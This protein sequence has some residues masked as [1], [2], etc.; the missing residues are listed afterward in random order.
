MRREEA[1]RVT[2]RLKL[3]H[4]ALSL[5]GDL[6]GHLRSVVRVLRGVVHHRWDHRAV[7]V[8]RELVGDETAR[9]VALSFQE[10]A[11]KAC[12]RPPVSARLHENVDDVPVLVDPTPQVP[13][14]P[15]NR[16]KQL[17]QIPPVTKA[18]LTAP[19]PT[20]IVESKGLTP[21]PNRFV[22][23]RDAPL[24]E[25]VFHI[26]ETKTE[27]MESHTAWLMIRGGKRYR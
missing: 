1:L 9:L 8:A 24:R 13:P 6:M 2:G 20:R 4:V 19:K 7:G 23:D 26:A 27:T 12:R 17:I 3:S 25:Q 21:V 22:R 14:P 10:L 18:P 16:D 5:P 15:L 11:E